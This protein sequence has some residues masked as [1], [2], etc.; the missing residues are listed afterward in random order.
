[1]ASTAEE[2][3]L[4]EHRTRDKEE[5]SGYGRSP[6]CC[7]SEHFFGGE[8]MGNLLGQLRSGAPSECPQG[9]TGVILCT[10]RMHQTCNTMCTFGRQTI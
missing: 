10:L 3:P 5:A 2:A 6:H 1:M 4:E 8:I 9:S 7:F